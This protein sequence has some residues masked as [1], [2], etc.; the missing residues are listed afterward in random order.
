[1][2]VVTKTHAVRMQCDLSIFR[3]FLV[4]SMIDS[5]GPEIFLGEMGIS[6]LL[7]TDREN[8]KPAGINSRA[9]YR[10]ERSEEL[11]ARLFIPED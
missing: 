3:D 2:Y 1:M 11:L 7:I 4:I 10:S 5:N 8:P 9:G 6:I